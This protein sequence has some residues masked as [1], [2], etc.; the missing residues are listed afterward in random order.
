VAVAGNTSAYNPGE[1][2]ARDDVSIQIY[3]PPYLFNGPRPVVTGVPGE[4]AYGSTL[5]VDTAGGP[6]VARALLMRPCAVTHTVDMDQRAIILGV[7]G[8]AGR[9][10]VRIP[11]DRTLAPPGY[12]MLF[13][14]AADGTPSVASWVRV[15]TATPIFS[16][17]E[18]GTYSGE[19]VIR[20]AFDGDVALEKIDQHCRVTLESR[21]GSITIR[22]KIDQHAYADLRAATTVVIG[23]GIDQHAIVRIE[24]G[25]DVTIGQK[26]NE[27]S[28]V[29]IDSGGSI[30]IGQKVDNYSQATLVARGG[31]HVGE[32]LDQH[33][34]VRVSARG[35]IRIEKKIDQHASV[36]LVSEE[37]SIR[38]GEKI[39]SN[40]FATLTAGTTVEIGQK[41]DQEASVTIVARST[42]SIGEKIDQH[43][44]ADIT[45]QHGDI[46]IGQG[47]SGSATAT[48]R[49]P[50]G[51][52]N[53]GDGVDGGS[54]LTWSARSL[55]CPRRDGT[56]TRV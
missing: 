2:N 35:D 32:S 36:D 15:T 3:N 28:Q 53:I 50:N 30:D 14:V 27:R 24:A 42:V 20:E 6:P 25:G 4:I 47:L 34:T 51:V 1:P 40:S 7:K 22:R 26:V 46:G 44:N 9:A 31:V 39:E 54:S 43:S 11:A 48:L 29:S 21:H 49:A 33:S 41:I 13:F 12:Y 16:P 10:S 18:L 19:C 17:I 52:V 5:E 23:E 38:I 55:H 45:S 37:G 56:I 8:G